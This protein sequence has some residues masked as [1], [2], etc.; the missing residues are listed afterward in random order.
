LWA[1]D[2]GAGVASG[3]AASEITF[4]DALLRIVASETW[5]QKL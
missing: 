4:K 2:E 5:T 3:A 1:A